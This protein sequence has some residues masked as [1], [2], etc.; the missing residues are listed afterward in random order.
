MIRTSLKHPVH[1]N[2]LY[3]FDM[4]AVDS[5]F[6]VGSRIPGRCY[7]RFLDYKL[8]CCDVKIISVGILVRI[9]S[10]CLS[11]NSDFSKMIAKK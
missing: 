1:R 9:T 5:N 2:V 3:D 10:Q 7:S 4:I 8:V 6:P 11:D